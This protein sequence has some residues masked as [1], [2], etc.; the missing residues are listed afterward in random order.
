M[1]L[2]D[3][4]SSLSLYQLIRS[5]LQRNPNANALLAPDRRPLT[6]QQLF[7]QVNYIGHTLRNRG[8]ER[9]DRVAVVL[10]N[11]PE[12]ATAFLGTAAYATSAPLNPSYRHDEFEFYLTD[13]GVRAIVH[14]ANADLPARDVAARLGLIVLDIEPLPTPLAGEF[15]FRGMPHTMET[16][17]DWGSNEDIALVLHTSGKRK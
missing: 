7:A 12:M 6:F 1:K 17:A 8:I 14:P 13:L 15:S 3:N 2:T 5:S 10:S 4:P 16:P 9:S 11:G